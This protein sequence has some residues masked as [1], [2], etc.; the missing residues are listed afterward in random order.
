MIN[1]I[2]TDTTLNRKCTTAMIITRMESMLVKMMMK[3]MG[4]A[5]GK[6]DD[7]VFSWLVAIK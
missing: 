4:I 3:P 1:M 7:S 6:W 2:W 5:T